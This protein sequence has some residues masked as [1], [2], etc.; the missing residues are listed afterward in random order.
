MWRDMAYPWPSSNQ[1]AEETQGPGE[2][3][4]LSHATFVKAAE[5][6]SSACNDK[7]HRMAA[8]DFLIST[9]VLP[10][11]RCILLFVFCDSLGVHQDGR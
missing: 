9:R 10:P 5:T 4:G 11:F 2:G 6:M 8:I 7:D 3:T 1:P